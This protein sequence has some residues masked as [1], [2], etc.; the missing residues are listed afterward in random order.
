MFAEQ[1]YVGGALK[2]VEAAQM[3]IASGYAFSRLAESGG[4]GMAAQS[5]AGSFVA[6][7]PDRMSRGEQVAG[8]T[9]MNIYALGS[10]NSE[11][12]EAMS[13]ANYDLARSGRVARVPGRSVGYQG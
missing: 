13:R 11:V 7:R 2:V 4:G 9:T 12:A 3:G 1:N 6:A 8:P 5:S 10:G